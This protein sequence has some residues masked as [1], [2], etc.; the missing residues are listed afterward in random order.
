[1]LME[2]AATV[3]SP[4]QS[5][6]PNVWC[7]TWSSWQGPRQR[8]W[9]RKEGR[10]RDAPGKMT[11]LLAATLGPSG[12]AVAGLSDAGGLGVALSC[13]SANCSR[14]FSEVFDDFCSVCRRFSLRDRAINR[15][16]VAD[17]ETRLGPAFRQHSE[18]H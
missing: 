10:W 14:P 12:G 4:R 11:S 18:C 6:G 17:K 8:P 13:A 5:P 15:E 16:K 3:L 2:Q 1:M 9:E 7:G